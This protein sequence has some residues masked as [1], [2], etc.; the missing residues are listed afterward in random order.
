MKRSLVVLMAMIFAGMAASVQA[1]NVTINPGSVALTVEPGTSAVANLVVTADSRTPYTIYLNVG[2]IAQGDLP[3]GWLRPVDLS[4]ATRTGGVATSV[5]ALVVNVPDATPSGSY[6]ALVIPQVLRT[7][8]AVNTRGFTVVVEVPEQKKCTGPPAF[9]NVKVGPENIWA[10]KRRRVE[11]DVSGNVV[12]APGCEVTGNYSMES[13]YGP[14]TGELAIGPDGAFAQKIKVKL[15]KHGKA[16]RG[17]V[18][19]GEL[20]V[21]DAEGNSATQGFFVK[22]GHDRGKKKGHYKDW[23]RKW[24]KFWHKDR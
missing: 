19:N 22:V 12:K 9:E 24:K 1:A 8:E 3:A 14:V 10:P 21:V 13:I 18:Y 7:T 11:I 6:T 2:R 17:K 15:S 16:R 4:L 20:T 5:L 23:K